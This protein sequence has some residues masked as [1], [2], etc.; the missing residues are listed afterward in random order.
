MKLLKNPFCNCK[1]KANCPLDNNGCNVLP[2]IYLAEVKQYN[3][4]IGTTKKAKYIGYKL[5]RFGTRQ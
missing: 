2:S 5:N 1:V 4:K 3:D